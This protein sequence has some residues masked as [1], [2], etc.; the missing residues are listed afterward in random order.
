MNHNP[1]VQFQKRPKLAFLKSVIFFFIIIGGG[2]LALGGLSLFSSRFERTY[3]KACTDEGVHTN[4]YCRC[5]AKES[6]QKLTDEEKDVLISIAEY[7]ELILFSPELASK[8]SE[9]IPKLF[10]IALVCERADAPVIRR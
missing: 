9:L 5:F 2:F 8:S 3:Y 4:Q 6:D 1:F 7:G 10:K